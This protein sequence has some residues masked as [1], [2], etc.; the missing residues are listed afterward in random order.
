MSNTFLFAVG[1][2]I[3]FVLVTTVAGI[4]VRRIK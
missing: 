3:F 2:I 1:V 4:I